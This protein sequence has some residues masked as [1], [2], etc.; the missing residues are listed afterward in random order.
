MKGPL[1]VCT[2]RTALSLHL[3]GLTQC[4]TPCRRAPAD[5][6]GTG[7]APL[8]VDQGGGGR[9]VQRC[10]WRRLPAHRSARFFALQR[11]VLVCHALTLGAQL[12]SQTASQ[13]RS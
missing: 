8:Q 4:C 12:A 10:L 5:V 7:E 3:L 2:K 9:L 1:K 11:Q 13:R 6:Q